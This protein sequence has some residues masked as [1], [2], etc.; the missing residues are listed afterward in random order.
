MDKNKYIFPIIVIG[1]VVAIILIVVFVIG[2]GDEDSQTESTEQTTDTDAP[3]TEPSDVES[4]DTQSGDEDV[5]VDSVDSENAL[6]IN[7][8]TEGEG[9]AVAQPGDRIT[10]DYEGRLNDKDGDVFDSSYE[11]GIPFDFVLGQGEVIA[12]WDQGLLNTKVGQILT[13]TIPPELGYG[14]NG[15]GDSIPPNSTLFFTVEVID[16]VSS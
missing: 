8:T 11:R 12:G 6:I 1:I 14:E 16:I 10:V 7:T 13:L 5:E 2:S 3:N 9:D 4:Q 15:V